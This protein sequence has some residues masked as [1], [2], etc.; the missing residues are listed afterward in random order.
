[1]SGWSTP[2]PRHPP[3]SALTLTGK[4]TDEAVERRLRAASERLGGLETTLEYLGEAAFVEA[5]T[6]S[7]LVV[8]PY[9]FMHNSGTALAAL[10]L[11][12]PVLVPDNDLNRAMSSE[13]GAGWVHLFA[14]ELTAGALL[15]AMH[16]VRTAPPEAPPDLGAREWHDAGRRHARAYRLAMGH[17]RDRS[18]HPRRRRR[19]PLGHGRCENSSSPSRPS[20]ALA[21]S[22]SALSAVREQVDAEND[23]PGS[24]MHCSILVVD[25]DAA[26]SGG[27]IAAEYAVL[28][29]I[30]PRP[31]YR[32]GPQ[33][34]DRGVRRRS[35]GALHRRR[36]GPGTGW[37]HAMIGMYRS[38][39]PAAVAGRVVT[40]FPDDVEPWV[41]ASGAFIRPTRVHG[42]TMGEAATNNLLV[43]LD[44]VRRLGL[45]FDER[46][47]L[48]GG[49]DSMFTLQLT[50]RGGSI[51]W[52]EDA[53][54]IE[55]EDPKRFTRSWVLMRTFR[56]GN[57]S[58]RV[59]IALT[60]RASAG[61]SRDGALS[62]A[63]GR[64]SSAGARDGASAPSRVRCRIA[65]A[66]CGP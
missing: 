59:R 9:R 18:T 61:P 26:G 3:R 56:F 35:R 4:P 65:H 5:V 45:A 64:A 24:P 21:P 58:A 29:V 22:A 25:N 66:A 55:Q 17:R 60:P 46:F 62:G 38:T 13:V 53:V 48:T 42:Q 44:G 23:A 2:S 14:G 47:G 40:R 39:G 54:V 63:V 27:R 7:E 50:R 19:R 49:S 1:M 36:R 41:A 33:P 57:T 6:S 30:Q 32:R 31:G 28:T 11:G 8:L 10:S 16:A 12:R 15:D 37:L 52:A 20:A 51:R 43:D 34:G